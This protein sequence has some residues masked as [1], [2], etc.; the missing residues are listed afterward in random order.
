MPIQVIGQPISVSLRN[1]PHLQA[2][3][4]QHATQAHINY[5]TRLA[6]GKFSI[7]RRMPTRVTSGERFEV[8]LRVT[9]RS[10]WRPA[11]GVGFRDALQID[12]PGEVTCGPSLALLAPGA[13]VEL[14]YEKRIH[15]RGLFRVS[16]ALAATRFPLGVF[17]HRVLLDAPSRIA[18]LPPLGRLQRSAQKAVSAPVA[19]HAA[20]SAR[21]LGE[22]EFDS[23]REY[24]SGDSTRMI[25]WRTSARAQTL[26]RRVL[27]DQTQKDLVVVLDRRI[28]DHA[29]TRH[30]EAAVSC[31]A[32]LLVHAQKERRNGRVLF[33]GGRAAHQ[34]THPTLIN[35]LEELA[36]IGEGED[37][38]D[39]AF[40]A[41]RSGGASEIVVVT[42]GASMEG[43]DTCGLRTH[44]WDAASPEFAKVYSRR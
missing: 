21:R 9:N 7:E 28:A 16:H 27:R 25:H 35:A 5:W 37:A 12:D 13:T 3:S 10:R 1:K 19:E 17:E 39:E 2:V 22:E 24:R 23:M 31:A 32:T 41:A 34:G 40:R 8:R 36:G 6:V 4:A 38:P 42:A 14:V 43:V 29:E 30:F 18:V 33:V 44:V 11:F 15:R 20:A 26:V